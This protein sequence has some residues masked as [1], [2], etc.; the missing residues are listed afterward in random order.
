M[1]TSL[2]DAVL[3]GIEYF[4][5]NEF[6]EGFSA[7]KSETDAIEKSMDGQNTYIKDFIKE[8][9]INRYILD[10]CLKTVWQD[11][12]INDLTKRHLY[13]ICKL[14][15]LEMPDMSIS[16]KDK[17]L[18]DAVQRISEEQ[19]VNECLKYSCE[20]LSYSTMPNEM[21]TEYLDSLLTEFG[22]KQKDTFF[23]YLKIVQQINV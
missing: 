19:R 20:L 14:L 3:N 4:T 18:I 16:Y 21:K 6:K 8:T 11:V 23:D 2:S 10:V 22:I 12:S 15:N 9:E 17:E 13:S 7:V 1:L 5:L